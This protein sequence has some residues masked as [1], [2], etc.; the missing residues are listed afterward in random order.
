[1]WEKQSQTNPNSIITITPQEIAFR[2]VGELVKIR[3]LGDTSEA[4]YMTID[5]SNN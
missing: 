5:S 3:R 2:I 4:N 1:M